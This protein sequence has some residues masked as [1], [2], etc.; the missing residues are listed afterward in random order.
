[1][2]EPIKKFNWNNFWLGLG[3]GLLLPFLTLVIYRQWSWKSF[4]FKHFV[5]YMIDHGVLTGILSLCLLPTL[6]LFFLFINK[7]KYKTC[8]GILLA[9][10]AYGFLILYVKI[11][12]EHS[13]DN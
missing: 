3:A 6:G 9:T 10:F 5:K 4:G 12:V 1:M 8:R 2:N 7:E 11:W 13:W